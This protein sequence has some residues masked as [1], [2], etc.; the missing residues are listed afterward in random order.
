MRLVSAQYERGLERIRRST[1][2]T[3]QATDNLAESNDQQTRS[4]DK[5]IA[6]QV[7]QNQVYD[8]QARLNQQ[9]EQAIKQVQRA[10]QNLA[11]ANQR[12][13]QHEKALNQLVEHAAQARALYADRIIKNATELKRLSTQQ[14]ESQRSLNRYNKELAQIREVKRRLN[15]EI[16]RNV[17]GYR[18][19]AQA[20][21]ELISL[22]NKEAQVVRQITN[23]KR[24]L[25]QLR[26]REVTLQSQ[27]TRA[28]AAQQLELRF[29]SQ[30]SRQNQILSRAKEK[31]R[32][33]T[34]LHENA[35]ARLNS[36]I[37]RANNI[38]SRT[39]NQLSQLR[40]KFS[41]N[42]RS[43]KEFITSGRGITTIVSVTATLVYQMGLLGGRL[44]LVR[45]Y[46]REIAT[47]QVLSEGSIPFP[48][49]ANQIRTSATQQAYENQVQRE[50]RSR[51]IR[52]IDLLREAT[53]GTVRDVELNAIA[54]QIAR[55]GGDIED[56]AVFMR[57]FVQQ[58]A[59]SGERNINELIASRFGSLRSQNL[60]ILEEVG[61]G[62]GDD[63]SRGLLALGLPNTQA[64]REYIRTEGIVAELTNILG[65]IPT[66]LERQNEVF[67][68][69]NNL[70]REQDRELA[71]IDLNNSF[72]QIQRL[73]TQ[74]NSLL[75]EIALFFEPLI[76]FLAKIV[77]GPLEVLRDQLRK[78][79]DIQDNQRERIQ[80]LTGA[81]TILEAIIRD[82]SS[83]FTGPS[84]TES[85][86]FRDA[87]QT[88]P[89][90]L[91]EPN[92]E[93]LRFNRNLDR[94]R[95]SLD[96]RQRLLTDE[97]PRTVLFGL[98]EATDVFAQQ[99]N[100]TAAGLKVYTDT[101]LRR[102]RL[103]SQRLQRQQ[104]ALIAA[105]SEDIVRFINE[106][107]VP[108][109]SLIPTGQIT[110]ITT[111]TPRTPINGA[112]A[113]P[114]LDA[115][116]RFLVAFGL[117]V[118][119]IATP[120]N[121]QSLN[122]L[123]Q[124][125]DDI[126]TRIAGL[127][128]NISA[129]VTSVQVFNQGG[130]LN[131]LAGGLGIVNTALGVGVP[132]IKGLANTLGIGVSAADRMREAEERLAR[133]REEEASRL[134]EAYSQAL[135]DVR[136]DELVQGRQFSIAG[137]LT[138]IFQG[139]EGNQIRQLT[140]LPSGTRE[141]SELPINFIIQTLQG[142]YGRANSELQPLIR[143]I[144]RE[145]ISRQRDI[146]QLE[147]ETRREQ[148]QLIIQEI[149]HQRRE[150]LDH[151]RN[152]EEAQRQAATRAVGLT[153]D[154]LEADLRASFTDQ[155]RQA[156]GSPS[157]R[158]VVRE[159]LF[160][161]IDELRSGESQALTNELNKISVNFNQ[162]RDDTNAYFDA[163]LTGVETAVNDLSVDFDTALV[164]HVNS[165][166]IKLN[167]AQ[168]TFLQAVKNIAPNFASLWETTIQPNI[169]TFMQ[170]NVA[171]PHHRRHQRIETPRDT[172]RFTRN[173]GGSS[174]SRN[175]RH[176]HHH[177]L[178]LNPRPTHR[179]GATP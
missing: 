10:K 17:G 62:T 32:T 109:R 42:I 140:G 5:A 155:F 106:G 124:A 167:E 14:A 107:P 12:V 3:A 34:L 82:I 149:E 44:R 157:A 70:I 127:I 1:R 63:P 120:E 73:R 128:R 39:L 15:V 105:T 13:I 110:P 174:T 22:A 6:A 118:E 66:Y 69:L 4:V 28:G 94:A 64:T 130:F 166:L 122:N 89:S 26:E 25:N 47:S 119:E 102:L 168:P 80:E 50:G 108:T 134:S 145:I 160:R 57:R 48:G 16:N 74:F 151:I 114:N 156:G 112:S 158:E 163:L 116:D 40:Q 2:E 8:R 54:A 176:H 19:S 23:E 33:A 143:N 20:S 51:S 72:I 111:I 126:D 101:E 81:P 88:R 77:S 11:S 99:L 179:T 49:G 9:Q 53:F 170:D 141:L 115:Y 93:N 153:F 56:S 18:R 137:F 148:A 113:G 164:T 45:D 92:E 125:F 75:D 175:C 138:S 91:G 60:G 132:L 59:L 165:E 131:Q 79:N 96:P 154:L 58:A 97:F 67:R 43:I 98:P 135:E 100:E 30:I 38:Y 87:Q 65:R 129:G 90:S 177:R 159:D 24:V 136:F 86:A 169:N 71:S 76:N 172:P 35:Q 139:I 68:R 150:V 84:R 61:F 27:Q 85:Q 52:D 104:D 7:R 161:Q 162:Q 123:A 144:I 146:T 37:R 103:S 21:R 178:R 133:L 152:A 142:A 83:V 41:E 55:M 95:E 29:L 46:Y 121:V 31:V 117:A 147:I 171:T 173:T 78:F 36:V